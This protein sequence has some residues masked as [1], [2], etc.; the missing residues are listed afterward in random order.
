MTTLLETRD[1]YQAEFGKASKSLPGRSSDRKAALERF[2]GLGFPTGSEESW[3]FTDITPIVET[4]FRAGSPGRVAD[5]A[6]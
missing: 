5:L 1:H 6:R 2:G 4:P 3:R